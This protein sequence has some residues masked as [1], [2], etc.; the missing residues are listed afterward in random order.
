MPEAGLSPWQTPDARDD[1]PA[2]ALAFEAV[3]NAGGVLQPRREE[4]AGVRCRAMAVD[5]AWGLAATPDRL[6]G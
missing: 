3:R 2:K 6:G 5:R 4:L 1:E